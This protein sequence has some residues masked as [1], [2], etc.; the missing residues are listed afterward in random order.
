MVEKKTLSPCLCFI[1]I[2]F[3]LFSVSVS[4][5]D[6][7]EDLDWELQYPDVILDDSRAWVDLTFGGLFDTSDKGAGL[8]FKVE[9]SMNFLIFDGKFSVVVKTEKEEYGRFWSLA[10][11]EIADYFE[12]ARVRYRELTFTF[13]PEAVSNGDFLFL[14]KTD[15]DRKYLGFDYENAGFY[16]GTRSPDWQAWSFAFSSPGFGFDSLQFSVEAQG[17]HDNS[18]SR[19]YAVGA[20]PGI[21]YKDLTIKP[22][23]AYEYREPR[24]T[25][26]A[27]VVNGEIRKGFLF[28]GLGQFKKG[29]LNLKG[30]ILFQD[31][32]SPF[33][34]FGMGPLEMTVGEFAPFAYDS[35]G[36]EKWVNIYWHYQNAGI[37]SNIGVGIREKEGRKNHELIYSDFSFKI[38]EEFFVS[39]SIELEETIRLALGTKYRINFDFYNDINEAE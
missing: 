27:T 22:F 33:F 26:A 32:L 3:L 14:P 12:D 1:F 31:V 35:L 9:P 39:F 29:I 10:N 15:I 37:D 21:H 20:G 16:F 24:S 4:A 7:F 28:G 17:F 2:F 5:E 18:A 6:D 23:A 19:T 13:G 8:F 25:D 11:E 36:R 30:G 34:L 38:A